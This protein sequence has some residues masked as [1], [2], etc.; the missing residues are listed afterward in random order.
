MSGLET[1]IGLLHNC[2]EQWLRKDNEDLKRAIERTVDEDLFS[3]EDIKHQVIHLKNSLTLES[4]MQWAKVSGLSHGSLSNKKIICL[5]AGNLPLVGLQDI[6]AVMMTGGSYAGKIS[7]K[8][9]Y[10]LLPLLNLLEEKKIA[11][12]IEWSITLDKL[13]ETRADAL[14][15]AGSESSK[16][17]V[18]EKLLHL[19]II[20]PDTPQLMRTAH[21][22]LAIIENNSKQTMEDLTEAVFRYGGTGCRSVAMVVAPFHLHSQKCSFTD[23]IEAFWMRNPQHKKPTPVLEHRFAYNKAIGIE[24]AWL[25]NFLIEEYIDKPDQKFILHWVKGDLKDIERLIDTYGSGL[26][27]VYSNERSGSEVGRR[28]FEPLSDAQTPP[29]WWRP[30]G[31]DTIKWLQQKV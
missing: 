31:I 15:F 25:N 30:D 26:Q 6:L 4:L 8:D 27:S 28:R 17:T 7:K 23:Y 13:S 19:K 21:F 11:K 1:H 24:Q 2:M 12:S 10:L 14:L 9:P 29:V 20:R 5:H 16:P 22:S 3:F 18:L